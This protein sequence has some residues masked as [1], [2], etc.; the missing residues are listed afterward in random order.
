VRDLRQQF[1]RDL[2]K[3]LDVDFG[4]TDKI[5]MKTWWH[6][7]R[8]SGGMRLTHA[9]YLILGRVL[10]LKQYT[11]DINPTILNNNVL[12]DL[13][14]KIQTPYYIMAKNAMPY[15]IVLFGDKEAM[16]ITLYGDLIKFLNNYSVDS[17]QKTS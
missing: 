12:L 5:A 7:I 6:N 9:G 11:F 8:P 15:K 14:R 4:I 2:V 1:T 16:L 13:D 17:V 3:K 10:D